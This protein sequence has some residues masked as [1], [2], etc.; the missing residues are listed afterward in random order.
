[1]NPK[2]N[3]Q[4]AL[5]V[6]SNHLTVSKSSGTKEH[7]STTSWF[8]PVLGVVLLVN[9]I[10]GVG[11][12][13]RLRA[14]HL[15]KVDGYSVGGVSGIRSSSTE[16]VALT[17]PPTHPAHLEAAVGPLF[18]MGDKAS[19]HHAITVAAVAAPMDGVHDHGATMTSVLQYGQRPD[20]SVLEGS[21]TIKVCRRQGQH[22]SKY[23]TIIRVFI[24]SASPSLFL[25][26]CHLFGKAQNNIEYHLH[27]FPAPDPL[28]NLIGMRKWIAAA[29]WDEVLKPY[30]EQP[31]IIVFNAGHV[32]GDLLKPE[33][34]PPRSALL[35]TSDE[36]NRF[37]F[38][39]PV[40]KL[41]DDGTLQPHQRRR[42][43]N[44]PHSSLSHA[45]PDGNG[46]TS[47]FVNV[48]GH[49]EGLFTRGTNR[50]FEE[51]ETLGGCNG[52]LEK[53]EKLILPAEV[54]PIFKQY[55]SQRQAQTFQGEFLWFPLGPRAEFSRPKAIPSPGESRGF[56]FNFVGSPT[57]VA[58]VKLGK[59][60]GNGGYLV[61]GVPKDRIMFHMAEEWAPG[62]V[63][64]DFPP[65]EY[66]DVLR[67]STFTLCP[68]GRNIDQFRIYEAI[69][70]G[71]I[72][73]LALEDG[74]A[75][76]S[77]APNYMTSPMVFVARWDASV[78]L[79]LASMEQNRKELK[80]RQTGLQTWYNALQDDTLVAFQKQLGIAGESPV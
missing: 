47:A 79:K 14:Q 45:G 10:F 28:L 13:W 9:F 68:G 54:T 11:M 21:P 46:W 71:S 22:P 63:E 53:I 37:G 35:L 8:G 60:F 75:T 31:N 34:W 19:A 15:I 80:T 27:T 20:S 33:A 29:S 52:V 57:S 12:G 76:K 23:T 24:W 43:Y 44:G 2:Y 51:C 67:N 73:V 65:S 38:S 39:L 5:P 56:L 70:C 18:Q 77:L 64:E 3:N 58:R 59:A 25:R 78:F 74:L 17:P 26:S 16:R 61:Q 36:S 41:H 55:Y 48:T 7:G 69:E 42:S 30:F 66:A 62:T 4:Y 6:R 49:L 40:I 50:N 72:P 1:M 32:P